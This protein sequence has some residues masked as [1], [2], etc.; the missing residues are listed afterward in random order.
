MR[1][2][3]IMYNSLEKNVQEV[4]ELCVEYGIDNAYD[5][6]NVI[7]NFSVL[8]KYLK[9][10]NDSANLRGINNRILEDL[11]KVFSKEILY[12]EV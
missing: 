10:Q 6:M 4:S 5:L 3:D 2:E 7:A 12:K 8:A 11:E 9:G 1:R